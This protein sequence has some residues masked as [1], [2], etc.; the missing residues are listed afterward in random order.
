MLF[1]GPVYCKSYEIKLK[2]KLKKKLELG[3]LLREK[4]PGVNGLKDSAFTAVKRDA[5]V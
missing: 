4:V 1:C 5:K 2:F 3:G